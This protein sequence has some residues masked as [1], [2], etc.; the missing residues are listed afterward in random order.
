M[1]NLGRYIR[2]SIKRRFQTML[3][4][5]LSLVVLGSSFVLWRA[6][7]TYRSYEISIKEVQDKLL[8]ITDMADHSNEIIMK[9]RG[10]YIFLDKLDYKGI[11]TA[12]DQ[13]NSTL[14]KLRTYPLTP[15]EADLTDK[16]DAFFDKYFR[17]TL[18]KGLALADKRDFESLKDLVYTNGVNP[19]NTLLQEARLAKKQA[20]R[21][22][23]T[24]SDRQIRSLVVQGAY[25]VGYILII[26]FLQLYM[27]RMLSKDISG[28]ITS[29]ARLTSGG[30]RMEFPAS[31]TERPDEVGILTRALKRMIHDI[32][33]NEEELTAQNEELFAQQEELQAQQ[34]E[35]QTALGK[36]EQNEAY[37][38]TLNR[39][40]KMLSNTD[41]K[42]DLL[43][44]AIRKL[45]E[46]S[47]MEKGVI[48]TLDNPP[49]Y[50]SFGMGESEAARA[51][52]RVRDGGLQ[53]AV[54]MRRPYIRE[55][56]VSE[57][58]RG[59]LEEAM[60]GYDLFV[61]VW[62]EKEQPAACLIL[63]RV[64]KPI[65]DKEQEEFAGYASQISLALS[66]LKLHETVMHRNQMIM[67]VLDVMHTG[68][69]LTD[70]DG[71]VLQI[72]AKMGEILGVDPKTIDFDRTSF[73]S[74]ISFM[75]T[76]TEEPERVEAFIREALTE[77]ASHKMM[78]Y[79]VSGP[80]ERIIEL[81][82]EPLYHNGVR[83]GTL[84]VH[85][86]ITKEHEV[87]RMKSE[88]VST[89]SHE[90]RTP[91]ASVLGFAELLL[92]REMSP[93]RRRK[94]VTTIHREALRLTNLINDFLDLQ[95]MESGKQTYDMKPV[96]LVPILNGL[97]KQ[98]Q[99][100]TN[101]HRLT[102]HRTLPTAVVLGDEEKLRQVLVNLLGNAVKYSPE[103][104]NVDIR[105]SRDRGCIRIEVQDEGLGIPEEAKGRLFEKFARVDNSDRREIGGTGL[106][107]A[108]VKE[109]VE[110]HQGT[111]EVKSVLGGGSTFTVVLPAVEN[112]LSMA[113]GEEEASAAREQAGKNRIVLVEN[114]PSMAEMLSEELREN[115]Y[116]VE[117]CDNGEA[118]W[119][120][121]RGNRPAAVVVDLM[122][123]DQSSG[124]R[125]IDR[126][127][128]AEELRNVPVIVSSALEEQDKG[129]ESGVAGYLVKP[130]PPG[131]LAEM[132]LRILGETGPNGSLE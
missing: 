14:A 44:R 129:R 83:T 37:L 98:Q 43:E 48:V 116:H 15:A 106:G 125:L 93:E 45:T 118:G 54:Q 46:M 81:Y 21:L 61:P 77:N 117:A 84:F 124:W 74:H 47:G 34:D 113:S 8:L 82:F 56:E 30:D 24:E 107:L 92:H 102:F 87:D 31:L 96:D 62:D 59:Y 60:R 115:G 114:D 12:R 104:G 109:I 36:M 35:L 2:K 95:R 29:L 10:Y 127:K 6:Y 130:Y 69:Q 17:T 11:F 131:K 33:E 105:C 128:A 18:S 97:T 85:R 51:A 71:R 38:L 1:L 103:G 39:F 58:E 27:A 7:D 73:A 68:V 57:A 79:A 64:G 75:R 100:V 70:A 112:E 88:F 80:D 3:F 89:V 123:E 110:R 4:L 65:S 121:V 19:I 67:D 126:M 9:T 101:R 55:R 28:P 49:A 78:R 63:T 90:L 41:A 26:L 40:T 42:R 5:G 122:L 91:L 23:V 52:Q 66:K 132:L 76:H 16:V 119:L 13:L 20:E 53:R 99:A 25:F 111:V 72:N 108:I 120:A 86:D 50:A 32:Q 22:L 94:Y